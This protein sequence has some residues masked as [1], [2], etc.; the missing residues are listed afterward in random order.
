MYASTFVLSFKSLPFIFSQNNHYVVVINR[1]QFDVCTL[2]CLQL[3]N[4][5][6][7]KKEEKNPFE[8]ISIRI[9]GM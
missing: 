2:K 8:K 9:M 4:N 5:I 3:V 6:N 7:A 1:T